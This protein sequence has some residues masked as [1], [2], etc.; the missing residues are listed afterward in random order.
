MLDYGQIALNS[1]LNRNQE[2]YD[3]EDWEAGGYEDPIDPIEGE[4]YF[5]DFEDILAEVMGEDFDFSYLFHDAPGEG[6]DDWSELQDTFGF[7]SGI[8]DDSYWNMYLSDWFDFDPETGEFK[9]SYDSQLYEQEERDKLALGL[10]NVSSSLEGSLG[11]YRQSL[12]R[13][14]GSNDLDISDIARMTTEDA[15]QHGAAFTAGVAQSQ[16]NWGQDVYDV[17]DQML[18][19]AQFQWWE[20]EDFTE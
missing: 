8:G 2:T 7:G 6:F 20:G 10:Q 16:M 1:S 12:G 19:E 17:I 11:K 9:S 15:A 4:G 18:G 13:G 5:A 14:L 3:W